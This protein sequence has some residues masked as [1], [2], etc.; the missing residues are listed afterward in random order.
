MGAESSDTHSVLM[1]NQVIESQEGRTAASFM[2]LLRPLVDVS[3]EYGR[4]KAA[5]DC[6]RCTSYSL[7]CCHFVRTCHPCRLH[8]PVFRLTPSEGPGL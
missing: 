2:F 6:A 7:F 4:S 8:I 1:N 5:N 3:D